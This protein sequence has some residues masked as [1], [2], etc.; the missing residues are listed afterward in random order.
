MKELFNTKS[1]LLTEFK[2]SI[3]SSRLLQYKVM[4]NVSQN[5]LN[6]DFLEP[7]MVLD[8]VIDGFSCISMVCII[9][10]LKIPVVYPGGYP[11]SNANILS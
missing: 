11:Y 1:A 10:N 2:N 9:Q 8:M 4:E 3:P 5:G 7:I 6:N